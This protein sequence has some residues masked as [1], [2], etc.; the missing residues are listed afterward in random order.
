M[1]FGLDDWIYWHLIHSTRYYRQYCAI[2]ILHTFQFAVTHAL[3]FSVFTSRILATDLSQSHCHFKSHKKSSLPV[4]FFSCHYSA[5]INSE[6]ST[7]FS[8]SAPT[9][10]SW[11][12]GVSKLDSSLPTTTL[13]RVFW[14]CPF[15]S[16]RHEPHG[17]QPLLLRRHVYRFVA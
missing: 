8:S 14:L 15:I 16:P 11:Q 5:V 6:D 4:S 10:I 13:G 3:G 12:A 17:K 9:L 1:G 2:A 7:P